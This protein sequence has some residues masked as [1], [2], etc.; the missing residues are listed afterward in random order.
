GE[1]GKRTH[2]HFVLGTRYATFRGTVR[3]H[4]GAPVAGARLLLGAEGPEVTRPPLSVPPPKSMT[5]DANGA[6][7]SGPVA[8]GPQ[9][10]PGRAARG[11]PAA[12]CGL[13]LGGC[14]AARCSTAPCATPTARPGRGRWSAAASCTRSARAGPAPPTTARTAS[15][16]CP[17][18]RSKGKR[19]GRA[20]S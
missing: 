3:N 11:A 4:A 12:R 14:W 18:A 2:V 13:A 5:T 20:T 7:D 17:T 10:L 19:S 1:P 9:L 16:I 6:F 8:P 15:T